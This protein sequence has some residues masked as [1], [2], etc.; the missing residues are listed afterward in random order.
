MEKCNKTVSVRNSSIELLRILSMI[1]IV[2]HHFARHGEFQFLGY[3]M[4]APKLW[5]NFIIM[6]GKI[7][8]NIFVMISGY[9]L[10]NNKSMFNFQRIKKTWDQ[11][12]FYSVGFEVLFILLYFVVKERFDLSNLLSSFFP[13]TTSQWWFASTYLALYLVHP[14]LNKILV[15]LDKTTYRNVLLIA[16]LC[17]SVIPTFTKS[18]Y[19]S[20]ELLWFIFIYSLSGY[21]RLYGFNPK[22]KNYHYAITAL[23]VTGLTYLTSIAISLIASKISD[24]NLESTYFY[25]MQSLLSLIISVC[26]FMMFALTDM[27]SSRFINTTAS[28]TF[29]V[30]LIHENHYLRNIFWQTIFKNSGYQ[31]S[32]MIIPVSIVAVISVYVLCTVIELI[33]QYVFEKTFAKIT[34]VLFVPFKKILSVAANCFTKLFG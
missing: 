22:Y 1:M 34:D 8:V 33:R 32:L 21:I 26:A 12:F 19:E 24:F 14:F 30:Y 16:F 11:V 28:A 3:E 17:W 20:N 9:F 13:I 29:G 10:I 23:A 18:S 27:K 7:G 15:S 4:T 5:Y 2:F 25:S 6:G 31:D